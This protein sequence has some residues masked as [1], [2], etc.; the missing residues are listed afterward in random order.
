MLEE[1][2]SKKKLFKLFLTESPKKKKK[3]RPFLCSVCSD[4]Y[5][6]QIALAAHQK[7]CF[8]RN[9]KPGTKLVKKVV[10]GQWKWSVMSLSDDENDRK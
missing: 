3:D 6:D 9:G 4:A 10:N 2:G 7:L 8:E 1:L 5:H